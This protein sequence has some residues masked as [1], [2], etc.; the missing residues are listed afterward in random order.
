LRAG[1]FKVPVGLEHLQSDPVT[2]FN[3]RSLVT[4]LVPNRDIG[5]QLWGDVAQG[6]FSYALGVFNGVGDGRSTSNADFEDHREVAGRLFFHPFKQSEI[7]AL[8]KFGIGVGGSWG[9]VSSNATGLTSAYLTD[10]Q[11]QFFTY[12]NGVVA[13]GDHWRVSPGAYY[14][15]G[16]FGVMAEYAISQQAV[17]AGTDTADLRHT[18]LQVAAG[19][20]LTGEDASFSGVTP[21]RPFN[22]ADRQ[23][24]AWQLVARYAELDIDNDAFPVFANP[25]AS[26]SHARSWAVGLNWYLNRNLRL[27]TSYSRTTFTGGGSGSSTPELVTSRPEQVLFT[28][29]QLTF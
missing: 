24:G 4:G 17:R 5:F 16:P 12:T 20:V 25:S 14:Y 3:E 1:K 22:L 27:N 29:L 13:D 6:A 7:P 9:S 18:G 19:W 11:Q 21:K 26:A 23:W 2:F 10:G 8:Q 15:F 28:R